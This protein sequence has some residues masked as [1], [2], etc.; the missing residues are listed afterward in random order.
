[1]VLKQSRAIDCNIKNRL[2]A[3]VEYIKLSN[4][5]KVDHETLYVRFPLLANSPVEAEIIFNVLR[6]KGYEAGRWYRPLLFPG[7]DYDK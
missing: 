2:N 6:S 7:V 5:L 1:M 4:T 3:A